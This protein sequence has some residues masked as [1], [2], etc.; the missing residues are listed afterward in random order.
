[1]KKLTLLNIPLRNL[2]QGLIWYNEKSGYDAG[3]VKSYFFSKYTL[4]EYDDAYITITGEGSATFNAKTTGA[5]DDPLLETNMFVYNFNGREWYYRVD[6][7]ELKNKETIRF[8]LVIDALTTYLNVYK[9]WRNSINVQKRHEKRYKPVFNK[10]TKRNEYVVD[11]RPESSLFA[12]QN[13]PDFNKRVVDARPLN[14]NLT[15]NESKASL[16]FRSPENLYAYAI[17]RNKKINDNAKSLEQLTQAREILPLMWYDRVNEYR[18][19]N[20]FRVEPYDLVFKQNTQF[21]FFWSVNVYGGLGVPVIPFELKYLV[22]TTK[23]LVRQDTSAFSVSQSI[24]IS[25]DANAGNSSGWVHIDVND[26][27]GYGDITMRYEWLWNANENNFTLTFDD[28]IYERGNTNNQL[29]VLE[30]LVGVF[31]P[32]QVVGDTDLVNTFKDLFNG[33]NPQQRDTAVQSINKVRKSLLATSTKDS[34]D[35]VDIIVSPFPLFDYDKWVEKLLTNSSDLIVK[36]DFFGDTFNTYWALADSEYVND[37]FKNKLYL[38]YKEYLKTGVHLGLR[39]QDVNSLDVMMFNSKIQR[40]NVADA[41]NN[42]YP[43]DLLQWL[44]GNDKYDIDQ[45]EL[46]TKSIIGDNSV[47]MLWKYNGGVYDDGL[48]NVNSFYATELYSSL[49]VDT[50]G[51]DQYYRENKNTRNVAIKNAKERYELG[52]RQQ[53][54][55]NGIGIL[56]SITGTAGGLVGAGLTSLTNPVSALFA[57]GNA[58]VGGITNMISGGIQ[59]A[60]QRE[61]M[62]I[63]YEQQMATFNAEKRDLQNRTIDTL[64][65]GDG[66]QK[67]LLNRHFLG[68]SGMGVVFETT[69]GGVL[70]QCERLFKTQGYDVNSIIEVKSL[71]DLFVR[72]RFNYIRATGVVNA[73]PNDIPMGAKTRIDALFSTGVELW[74]PYNRFEIDTLGNYEFNNLEKEIAELEKY[75]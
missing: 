74:T 44:C 33:A 9:S 27:S 65:K 8:Y 51:W 5:V 64:D 68:N 7:W 72:H 42:I 38:S 17:Y 40:M 20:T 66:V 55:A 71:T 32:Y 30:G 63:G 48:G 50:S 52:V 45:I 31:E 23:D 10:I 35:L 16:M 36:N 21:T 59:N 15:E 14:Y 24:I 11:T 39:H 58:I 3:A 67:L 19:T 70:A 6:Y 25:L 62:R 61:Q 13:L 49:R 60:Q 28:G 18:G 41:N 12:S 26:K 54:L 75:K 57:G 47:G 43:F 22:G 2:N 29:G 69:Y 34:I 37:I 56:N 1:M 73:L 4:K 46:I 53:K